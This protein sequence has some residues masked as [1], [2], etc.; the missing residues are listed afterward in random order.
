[1][2]LS[3]IR[4]TVGQVG[5]TPELSPETISMREYIGFSAV[6]P[7]ALDDAE[8]RFVEDANI[9]ILNAIRKARRG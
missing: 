8:E 3:D 9:M 4:V 7:E 5:A 2:A 6:T 1:M